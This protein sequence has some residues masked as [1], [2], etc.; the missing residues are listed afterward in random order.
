MV[1]DNKNELFVVVDKNDRVIGYKT[2]GECHANKD[3]IHRGIGVIVTNDNDEILLQQRSM[4]K[5]TYPGFW[6][7]ATSGHVGKGESYEQAARREMFEE[8]G[9]QTDIQFL[10]KFLFSDGRETEYDTLFTADYNGPFQISKEEVDQVQFVTKEKLKT[11]IGLF[12]PFARHC[13]EEA[14]L[15]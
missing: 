9:I 3:L 14:K 11:M 15:L 4:S 7:I 13:L 10:T 6:T 5:D 12:S 2:R 8:I 1:T